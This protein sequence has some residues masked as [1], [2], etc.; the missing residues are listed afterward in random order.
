MKTE[1]PLLSPASS[2]E[3]CSSIVHSMNLAGASPRQPSL[4][5]MGGAIIKGWNLMSSRMYIYIYMSLEVS[6]EMLTILTLTDIGSPYQCSSHPGYCFSCSCHG[7]VAPTDTNVWV[8]KVG[9]HGFFYIL[10]MMSMQGIRSHTF[11]LLSL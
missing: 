11:I 8:A 7:L 5:F 3:Y 10:Y 6:P 1:V 9:V 4:R 2:I